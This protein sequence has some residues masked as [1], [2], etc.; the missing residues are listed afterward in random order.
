MSLL[1][2]LYSIHAV[3]LHCKNEVSTVH[4]NVPKQTPVVSVVIGTFWCPVDI[5]VFIA[6]AAMHVYIC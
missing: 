6:C 3:S 4:K 1:A 2:E 5:S